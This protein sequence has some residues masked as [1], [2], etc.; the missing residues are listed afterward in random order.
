MKL[1]S[2]YSKSMDAFTF[3]DEKPLF[4]FEVT[5]NMTLADLI[6]EIDALYGVIQYPSFDCF[7]EKSI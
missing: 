3:V 2:S 7:K 4:N 1:T 5:E 6:P